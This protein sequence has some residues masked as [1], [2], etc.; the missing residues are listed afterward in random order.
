MPAKRKS[1]GRRGTGGKRSGEK[2]IWNFEEGPPQELAAEQ[3]VLGAMLTERAAVL[4]AAAMLEPR[5]FYSPQHQLLYA[6]MMAMMR[7]GNP[8]DMVTLQAH[9]GEER[10]A[11]VGGHSY[12]FQMQDE[13]PTSAGIRAYAEIVRD[14]SILRDQDTAMRSYRQQADPE[15]RDALLTALEKSAASS[16]TVISIDELI[17]QEIEVEWLVEPMIPLHGVTVVIADTGFGKS[18]FVLSLCHAVANGG[19]KWLGKYQ[20]QRRGGALLYDAEVGDAGTRQRG[21]DLDLGAGVQSRV[22]KQEPVLDAWDTEFDGEGEPEEAEEKEARPFGLCFDLSVPLGPRIGTL[23]GEIRAWKARVVVFDNLGELKDPRF[24]VKSND[25]MTLV[26]NSLRKLA[27]K[28]HCAIVLVHDIR[29]SGPLGEYSPMDAAMGAKAI[30]SKADSTLRIE[31]KADGQKT[32]VHAKNRL[33][34]RR[35]PPFR[36][37]EATGPDGRGLVLLHDGV[38]KSDASGKQEAAEEAITQCLGTGASHTRAELVGMITQATGVSTHTVD[39]AI[40]EMKEQ[41]ILVQ[42][43]V[44]KQSGKG[45]EARFWFAGE[46]DS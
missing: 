33:S 40:A 20:I 6:A 9:L 5:D 19:A 14:C 32:V 42:R 41:G 22:V 35:E 4:R 1:A 7:D 3:A 34:V 30:M 13:A 16:H 15:R 36:L 11:E 46:A 18:L 45:K 23:E 2:R 17:A 29:K 27:R 31:G 38:V 44:D 26:I 10:W 39:R 37:A 21:L 25:D 43:V 8:V 28:C 24:E 12:L